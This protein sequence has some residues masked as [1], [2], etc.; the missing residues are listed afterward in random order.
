LLTLVPGLDPAA[1]PLLL[2]RLLGECKSSGLA[3]H[4]FQ[5]QTREALLSPFREQSGIDEGEV[6]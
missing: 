4:E 5:Q 1:A 6:T 2:S 3:F